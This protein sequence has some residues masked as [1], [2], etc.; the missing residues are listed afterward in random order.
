M[1]RRVSD[2]GPHNQ[3]LLDKPR[4]DAL[5][6]QLLIQRTEIIS[7]SELDVPV[8]GD[9]PESLFEHRP[10]KRGCGI[11]VAVLKRFEP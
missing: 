3:S 8:G 9:L 4:V 11:L 7:L 6:R 5:G 1:I 10:A 2:I